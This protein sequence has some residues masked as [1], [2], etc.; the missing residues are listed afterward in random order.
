M[1]G[2][3]FWR[4]SLGLVL[5]ALPLV[6]GCGQVS[7]TSAPG[8]SSA[9]NQ[10]AALETAVATNGPAPETALPDVENAPGKVVSTATASPQNVNLTRPA[11]EVVKLT[12]AGVDEGVMLAFV[13]NSTSTF[14]LDSEAVIYLNDIGVSDAVVLSMIQHDQMLRDQAL[15]SAQAL[16]PPVYV[17]QTPAPETTVESPPETVESQA[18]AMDVV[19]E[20]PAAEPVDVSY[21][22]F[23]SSLAPY[24]SWINIG[25]YG[26][27]W[28]PTVV[29]V[30][31]GWRPYCDRGRWVYTDCGWYWDSAYSWGWAPFHYGRWFQHQQ[32]GWCWTPGTVWGPSWVS[33]RYT[34]GYCGWA[35][36]PPAAHYQ[37]GNGFMYQGRYAGFGS[38]FGLGLNSYSFVPENR[39]C[40]PHPERHR[41]PPDHV[42]GFYHRTVPVNQF[43][44]GP[45][46]RVMNKGIPV[47]KIAADTGLEI[48]P[49]R[50]RDATYL[51]GTRA[52]Y[53]NPVGR[54]LTVYRPELSPLTPG[55]PAPGGGIGLQQQGIPAVQRAGSPAAGLSPVAR[56]PRTRST[57][58][59][60]RPAQR[61]GQI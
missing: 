21:N 13:T 30:N 51:A 22:Y 59:C 56:A 4:W 49:V 40:D 14:N 31:R 27:C 23:Y 9:T 5:A 32:W 35:P 61:P 18:P 7:A 44:Q 19:N 33:W 3:V 50:L 46:H 52:Q 38:G 37:P 29:V 26:M 8:I 1:K 60:T 17:N 58:R 16:A 6:N 39:F 36:L 41:V 54:T 57:A 55:T 11:A 47:K 12:Q 42:A 43:A 28:Q 20:T 53:P 45:D 25:G 24:G 48:R 10:P 2:K 34:P 15:T